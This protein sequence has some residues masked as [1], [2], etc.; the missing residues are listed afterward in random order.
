M[1]R[2]AGRDPCISI[3]RR[4][5]SACAC[6]QAV[7]LKG[8]ELH[9]A[10]DENIRNGLSNRLSARVEQAVSAH[11]QKVVG[12]NPRAPMKVMMSRKKGMVHAMK[13]ITI[14]DAFCMQ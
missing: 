11:I 3:Q 2:G 4:K 6:A 7:L 9:D 10:W 5:N 8:D 14:M 12:L 13:A 1:M